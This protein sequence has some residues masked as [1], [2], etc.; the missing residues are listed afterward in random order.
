MEGI[1]HE[2]SALAAKLSL[3]HLI[4]IFDDNRITIDGS[5]EISTAEDTLKRYE[6]YGW[7]VQSI[8][9]HSENEI[10][11][12]FEKA[13]V[14]PRPSII[15]CRTKIGFGTPKEGSNKAHS[16]ALSEEELQQTK[17]NLDWPYENFEIPENVAESWK[18][19]GARN[20][21][22]CEKWH[23]TQ[24]EK[25]GAQEFEYLEAFHKVFRSIKKE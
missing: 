8:D 11:E 4:V 1:S 5:I 12:A 6:A 18:K 24:A 19:F 7:H 3:G 21:E 9:G 16:G 25:Y 20:H 15:A 22:L 2:A 14:D 17:K 13:K 10:K 23:K